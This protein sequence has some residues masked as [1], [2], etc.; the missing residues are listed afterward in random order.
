MMFNVFSFVDIVV[1]FSGLYFLWLEKDVLFII[2]GIV[3]LCVFLCGF[4]LNSLMIYV[5]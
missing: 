5:I 1:V 3:F 2:I 4:V